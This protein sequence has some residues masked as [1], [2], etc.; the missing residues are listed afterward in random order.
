MQSLRQRRAELTFDKIRGAA[1]S[2]LSDYI[3]YLERGN[4]VIRAFAVTEALKL[5]RSDRRTSSGALPRE[6]FI[7]FMGP[8]GL[9]SLP[10]AR[11]IEDPVVQYATLVADGR[12]GASSEELD[13][14][15][16]VLNVLRERMSA[17]Q[18]IIPPRRN[19]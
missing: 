7:G 10:K 11:F 5:V 16:R 2:F 9:P 3:C 18:G 19:H 8:E 1:L 12:L 17:G 14:T 15:S 4:P 6:A 13:G